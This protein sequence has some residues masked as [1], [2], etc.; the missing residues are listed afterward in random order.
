MNRR[1]AV[2]IPTLNEE[3]RIAAAVSSALIVG[4]SEVIVSD[5]G[6]ADRTAEVASAAGASVMTAG[7]MRS[8]QLNAAASRSSSEILIFLHGDS[9]LPPG[10]ARLAADSLADGHVF[11]GF[12]I[13]FEETS[14]RLRLAETMINL[15]TRLTR[16]PWGDQAQFI[17][18]ETFLSSGGFREIAMMED[19]DLA[20][21]MKRAGRTAVLPQKVVTSGRR[22][23]DKGV[24]ATAATNWRIILAYRLGA[25]P[26]ELERMYR[27]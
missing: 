10:A 13:S 26:A 21:R 9:K 24:L 15:R 1:V 23:L 6:S 11:G 3:T 18:R 12:Q 20:I 25:D 7:P 19:Y 16:C 22:F 4:A 27:R 14:A 8:R 2:I 17:E 5:G